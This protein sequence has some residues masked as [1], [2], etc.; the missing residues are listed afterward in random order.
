MRDHTGDFRGFYHSGGAW[1]WPTSRLLD[2][3]DR[4]YFGF[5]APDGGTSGEMSMRWIELNQKPT[6]QL[7]VF[8]DSWHSL[9]GMPDVIA[10]LAETDEHSMTPLVFCEL[11]RSL[12][13]VDLTQR[14]PSESDEAA[15]LVAQ[16]QTVSWGTLPLETLRAI[17]TPQHPV[18][19]GGE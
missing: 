19:R 6:P 4:V 12:G 11:L 15:R 13:F 18:E 2:E 7:C 17:D 3:V 9:G 14:T 5:Y 1:H 8:D 10:A 16:M